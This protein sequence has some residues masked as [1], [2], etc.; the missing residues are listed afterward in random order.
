MLKAKIVL[1]GGPCAGKTTALSKIEEDLQEL[2]YKVLVVSESATELIKGGIRPFGDSKLDL[3]Y[4][5]TLM[6]RYQLDKEKIYEMAANSIDGDVVIIYDR[7]IVDNKAYI[8]QQIFDQIL[9]SYNLKEL[10]LMDNYDIV[11]HLV[12]AADGAENFYTLGNNTARTETVE[13]AMILDRKTLNAWVG[14]NN[15]KIIDNSTGFNDKLKRVLDNIHNLLGLPV[16]SKKERK[17]LIDLE[18]SNLDYLS[19]RPIHIEQYY[20]DEETEVRLR[21]RTL[22]EDTT[23][24]YTEQIKGKDGVSTVLIDKKITEKEFHKRLLSSNGFS[25]IEKDRYSFIYNK[26]YYKL[27][28]IDGYGILEVDGIEN[29]EIPNFLH[30]L[31][32]VT[33]NPEYQNKNLAKSKKEKA[34]VFVKK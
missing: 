12:T 18:R 24:Y 25:R 4:F 19:N 34:K 32:E 17:F 26:N 27:D 21:K 1:T 2:G 23:Y 6:I 5:Q 29:I 30:V 33:N 28:I 13:E 7:G 11:L 15:L 9:D 10:T 14:H 3:E 20:L 16:T 31:D 8:N 22:K